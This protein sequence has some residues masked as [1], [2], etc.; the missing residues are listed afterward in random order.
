MSPVPPEPETLRVSVD[1]SV[2]SAC[3]DEKFGVRESSR[4]LF[5][6]FLRARDVLARDELS[7]DRRHPA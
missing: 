2:L 7:Q 1:T 6:R 5:E 3:E 4:R